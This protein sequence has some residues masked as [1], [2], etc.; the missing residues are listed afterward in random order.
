MNIIQQIQ[1]NK[2]VNRAQMTRDSG[3]P[4]T[5][6]TALSG[7]LCAEMRYAT[8]KRIADY[9]GGMKPAQ[10]QEAYRQWRAGETS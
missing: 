6:L 9:A 2:G 3:I 5:T 1:A 8:A 7:G 10:V 4:Y